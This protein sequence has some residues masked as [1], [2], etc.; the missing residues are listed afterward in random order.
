VA[1]VLFSISHVYTLMH[2]AMLATKARHFDDELTGELR[3]ADD[4]K[5]QVRWLLPINTFVQFLA[6]PKY[7]REGFLQPLLHLTV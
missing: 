1:P 3:S 2:F 5:D 4:I 7:I 6:G